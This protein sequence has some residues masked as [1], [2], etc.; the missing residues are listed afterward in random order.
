MFRR[1]DPLVNSAGHTR[2]RSGLV[3]GMFGSP[4]LFPGRPD[5]RRHPLCFSI[6]RKLDDLGFAIPEVRNGAGVPKPEVAV[7]SSLHALAAM[8]PHV[9]HVRVEQAVLPPLLPSQLSRQRLHLGELVCDRRFQLPLVQISNGVYGRFQRR[10]QSDIFWAFALTWSHAKES[11]TRST[12]VLPNMPIHRYARF[13]ALA[14]ATLRLKRTREGHPF[15]NALTG[16]SR[17]IRSS[18]T[19]E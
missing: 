8:V 9:G 18:Q 19:S 11:N 15:N 5:A 3:V 4:T 7:A 1:D 2:K 6:E 13:S 17:C 12:A 10:E 16:E 14:L